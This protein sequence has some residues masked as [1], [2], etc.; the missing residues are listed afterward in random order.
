MGRV[1]TG[2]AKIGQLGTGRSGTGR[3]R[4]ELLLLTGSVVI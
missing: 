1:G 3:S 4:K 2:Q